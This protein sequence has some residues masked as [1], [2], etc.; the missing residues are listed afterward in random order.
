MNKYHPSLLAALTLIIASNLQAVEKI[1]FGKEIYPILRERCL[2]CH[3]APYEDTRGRIRKPKDGVRLDTPEWIQKGHPKDDG[4]WK[5]IVTPG[6]A[7]SSSFYT[8]TI[9]PEDHDDIMPARGNPLSKEQTNLLKNWINQGADYGDFE[10]P[11]YV[12][13]KSKAA[14][15]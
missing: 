3:A 6:A 10:A 13:P 1:D 8:L 5:T 14:Q 9:L 12:N 11:E 4:T 2:S 7:E 15:E